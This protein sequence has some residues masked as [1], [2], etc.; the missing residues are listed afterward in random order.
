MVV[1]VK[2]RSLTVMKYATESND[3]ATYCCT[4]DNTSDENGDD[5]I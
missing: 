4:S 1:I 5:G 2:I 3:L